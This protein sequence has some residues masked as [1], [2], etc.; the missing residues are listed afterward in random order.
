MA[1]RRH[2][3]LRAQPSH[4]RQ[5]QRHTLALEDG[6]TTTLHV[7]RYD[8]RRTRLRVVAL[9]EPMQLTEWCARNDAP[10]ALVGGFYVRPHGTPLGELRTGGVVRRHEPFTAP[11]SQRRA[12]VHVAEGAVRIAGREAIEPDPAG[13]LLQ[14]GPL[15]VHDG[16][17]VEGDYEGFSAGSAQF[18]SDITVGR[19]PRAAFA[20]GASG[21][22]FAVACDG[23]CDSDCGLSLAELA[24]ALVDLGAVVALNLDGGGSTSL[25]CDGRLV[26][27]PREA[28]DVEIAGGRAVSTA[29]VFAAR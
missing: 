3:R 25:V 26:N 7:A 21:E 11:W 22:L 20:I 13:D 2:P 12:C 19:Y 29:L 17:V 27:V 16:A 28:H 6:A 14:A 4:P 9:D 15:L 5:L 23:R 24:G 10:D 1:A 18:D 8:T